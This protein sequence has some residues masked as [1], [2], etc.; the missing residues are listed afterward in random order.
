MVLC[1]S[2][3]VAV[4]PLRDVTAVQIGSKVVARYTHVTVAQKQSGPLKSCVY[5]GGTGVMLTYHSW[6]KGKDMIAKYCLQV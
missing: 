2:I 1:I 3:D 5:T 4:C 6:E